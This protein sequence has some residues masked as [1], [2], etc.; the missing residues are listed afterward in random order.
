MWFL[1]HT[2]LGFA[3]AGIVLAL[4]RPRRFEPRVLVL[5]PFLANLIDFFHLAPIRP[6]SHSLLAATLLPA[7]AIL[8]WH[9]WARWSRTEAV[10]LFA[11]SLA[12]IV[13]DL[14]FGSF[15]PLMPFVRWDVE[16]LAF[17]SLADLATEAVLGV[18]LIAALV[19]LYRGGVGPRALRR[20]PVL[21]ILSPA[22][23]ILVTSVVFWGEVVTYTEGIVWSSFGVVGYAVLVELAIV[24][25]LVTGWW[26]LAARLAWR[27]T[28][29][30]QD[31]P[32]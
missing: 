23:A 26:V 32:R 24:A 31:H 17:G 7:A 4:G 9:R 28:R 2:A 25:G 20:F 14:T 13:G 8:I 5:V 22:G 27:D 11:A 6:Y 10:A 19:L 30:R 12:A 1:G 15:Y 29:T 18:G 3:F 21:W 16:W